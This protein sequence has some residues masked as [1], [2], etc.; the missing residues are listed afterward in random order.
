MEIKR[1]F[2]VWGRGWLLYIMDGNTSLGKH[3]IKMTVY[4]HNTLNIV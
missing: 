1:G 3:G 4:L 2:G